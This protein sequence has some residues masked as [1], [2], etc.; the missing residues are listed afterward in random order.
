MESSKQFL[1]L[2][3][4]SK[5]FLISYKKDRDM[6]KL[7]KSILTDIDTQ[8]TISSRSVR[9][10]TYRGLLRTVFKLS[11][12]QM[13]PIEASNSEKQEYFDKS[14]VAIES[15]HEEIVNLALLKHII[16]VSPVCELMV[17]SGLRISELLD[18]TAK[19]TKRTVK[20]KLNKKKTK[21]F[22][23]I[24]IIGS[25]SDWEE[26][27]RK[28]KIRFKDRSTKQIIDSVNL[29]LKKILPDGFYKRSSHLCR[30]IYIRYLYKFK[31]GADA[32]FTFPQIISKYLH[33]DSVG[34]SSYYQ[35]I[36]LADNVTDF[37]KVKKVKKIVLKT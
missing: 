21:E 20:F 34:A 2:P 13:I 18:N 12:D 10:S 19:F 28:L 11:D 37:L 15:Q 32:K 4:A 9:R 36:V 7:F 8:N 5:A 33:H 3:K 26:K 22:H 31:S 24:K 17:R 29:K 14:K 23:T 16:A 35:H 6:K 1:R 25:L 27:Y 30:A